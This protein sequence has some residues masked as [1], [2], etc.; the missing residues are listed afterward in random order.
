MQIFRCNRAKPKTESL[1][2]IKDKSRAELQK[3]QILKQSRS[4]QRDGETT[5]WHWFEAEGFNR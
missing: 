4:S 1:E 2:E 3:D 5:I